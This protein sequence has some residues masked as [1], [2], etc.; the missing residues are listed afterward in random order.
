MM[1]MATGG[2]T[3]VDEELP[4]I[5]IEDESLYWVKHFNFGLAVIIVCPVLVPLIS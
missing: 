5:D 2:R 1:S 4:L 3:Y